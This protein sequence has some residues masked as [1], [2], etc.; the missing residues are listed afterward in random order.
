M[1]RL[2]SKLEC[3]TMNKQVEE[4]PK[5]PGHIRTL[6][7]LVTQPSFDNEAEACAGDGRF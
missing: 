5:E 2:E 3:A 7:M 1:L 6:P 4:V